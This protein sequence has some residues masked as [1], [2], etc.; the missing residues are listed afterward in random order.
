MNNTVI[1]KSLNKPNWAGMHRYNK[2]HDHVVAIVNR[3]GYQTGLSAEEARELEKKLGFEEGTLAPHSIYWKEYSV[4]LTDRPLHMNLENPQDQ[5]DYALLKA[6]PRVANS[7][8]ELSKWPKAEYV[9]YDKEEDAKRENEFIDGEAR[10]MHQFVELTPNEQRNYLKLLGKNEASMSDA[11]VR[12]TLFK[13]AKDS[14]AEFNKIT[15]M[16]NKK[17]KLLIYDL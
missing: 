1:V 17:Y 4:A 8:N 11:V 7:L 13:I 10:A 9:I 14:S 3:K 6:S 15:D 2:C 12:N 5:L 16:P